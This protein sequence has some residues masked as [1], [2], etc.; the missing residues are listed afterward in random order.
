MSLFWGAK[1]VR[2]NLPTDTCFLYDIDYMPNFSIQ[3]RDV[4]R[5]KKVEVQEANKYYF[6]ESG[7]ALFVSFIINVF[8]VAVFAEGFYGKTNDEIVS[9]LLNIECNEFSMNKNI[10]PSF[11]LVLEND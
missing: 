4:D 5:K 6:I 2:L 9:I 10:F 7:I 11:V 1:N 8:V 3:S